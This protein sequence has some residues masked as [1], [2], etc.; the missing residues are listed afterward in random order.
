[1]KSSNFFNYLNKIRG[2]GGVKLGLCLFKSLIGMK[3][4]IVASC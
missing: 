4:I 1:M 2:G 3:G